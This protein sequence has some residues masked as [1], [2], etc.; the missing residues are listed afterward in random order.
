MPSIRIRIIKI[1]LHTHHI[2]IYIHTHTH[3]HTYTYIFIWRKKMFKNI[4]I[5]NH[6]LSITL[7]SIKIS[8]FPLHIIPQSVCKYNR[9]VRLFSKCQYS[10]CCPVT[11]SCPTLSDLHGL[12]HARLICPPLYPVCSLSF[13][14]SWQCYLTP[15]S[16]PAPFSSCLQSFPA[17]GLFQ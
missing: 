6:D 13:P 17:Q 1:A 7:C 15:H 16:L 9:Q 8:I 10:R 4:C 14:L 5:L 11:K 2:Y 3:T 12:Q